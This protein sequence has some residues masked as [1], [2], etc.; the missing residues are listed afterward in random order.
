M[1]MEAQKSLP[2][3]MSEVICRDWPNLKK[4][5][6][7]GATIQSWSAN[8]NAYALNN[9]AFARNGWEDYV[10]HAALLDG[11][12]SGLF[13]SVAGELKPLFERMIAALQRVEKEGPAVSPWMAGYDGTRTTGGSFLPDGYTVVYLLDQVGTDFLERTLQRAREKASDERE[14]RQMAH[15]SAVVAY[16][17]SAAAAL[18]LDLKAKKAEKDGNRSTAAAL[19]LQAAE[20]CEGTA[21]YLKTLPQRGWISVATPR[22]W[23]RLATDFRKRAQ[24]LQT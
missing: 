8:H 5:G 23:P 9:L 16:W 11:Y 3:P 14:R 2:Y 17:R 6:I 12:L 7:E 4:L 19:L 10:N 22:Q 20:K 15:F 1:G 24:E 18:E 13:G 21:E